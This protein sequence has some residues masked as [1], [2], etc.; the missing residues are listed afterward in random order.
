MSLSTIEEQVF[1][2]VAQS[3]TRA[4]EFIESGDEQTKRVIS[5]KNREEIYQSIGD[6][7]PTCDNILTESTDRKSSKSYAPT[8]SSI[9]VEHIV[10]LYIGSNNK[11]GNLVAMCY[12]CNNQARNE[13]QRYFLQFPVQSNRGKLLTRE[14]EDII[15][16]FTEWSIRSIKTPSTK[17]DKEIQEYFENVRTQF[18]PKLS[19]E[20]RIVVLEKRIQDLENTPVRVLF[21]FIGRLFRMISGPSSPP[22][23]D[24]IE[25]PPVSLRGSALL[26]E[27]TESKQ[28]VG[29]AKTTTQ[30]ERDK[31]PTITTEDLVN[32]LMDNIEDGMRMTVIGSNLPKWCND[33]W[34]TDFASP[35]E[36]RVHLNLSRN[37]TLQRVLQDLL[38]SR[39]SFEG[40]AY[41]MVCRISKASPGTPR[42]EPF[43]I[44]SFADIIRMLLKQ[45]NDPIT[46]NSLGGK[47]S[48][49][50]DDEYDFTTKQFLILEGLN[51]NRSIRQLIIN[52]LGDDVIISDDNK[53]V[54]LNRRG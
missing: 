2:F 15:N 27:S 32:V 9:T 45:E 20:E 13:T 41:E 38:G 10:P 23:G 29:D 46:F 53:E 35:K 51:E 24:S 50:L 54:E 44:K 25:A 52:Q 47:L 22:R 31:K 48:K 18:A 43:P 3:Q 26:A 40:K 28:I 1:E 37:R 7:C 12:A 4:K 19:L 30:A 21:R 17:I 5:K 34:N 16:R 36:I 33:A 42:I 14:T 39:V 8:S 49:F 6:K 11:L